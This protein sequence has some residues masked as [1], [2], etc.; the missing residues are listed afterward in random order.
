M[1]SRLTRFIAEERGMC[2]KLSLIFQNSFRSSHLG[3]NVSLGAGRVEQIC[4]IGLETVYTMRVELIN[5]TRGLHW[6][7]N[8]I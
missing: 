7:H 6:D 4:L 1:I 3:T 2:L 8:C 5:M